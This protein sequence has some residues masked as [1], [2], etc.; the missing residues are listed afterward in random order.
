MLV[1]PEVPLKLTNEVLATKVPATD[2]GVPVALRII[3]AVPAFKMLP[4]FTVKVLSIVAV[5]VAGLIIV[6]VALP[7][8][9]KL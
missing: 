5:A 9:V 1:V 8:T 2:N 7:A 4:E 6:V 3:E